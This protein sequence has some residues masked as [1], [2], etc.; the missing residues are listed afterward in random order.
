MRY[1]ALSFLERWIYD[2][3]LFI[4]INFKPK[5]TA[6]TK[7]ATANHFILSRTSWNQ[8]KVAKQRKEKAVIIFYKLTPF[9]GALTWYI[10]LT[11]SLSL[12]HFHSVTQLLPNSL[13]YTLSGILC[14]DTVS[15]SLLF[16]AHL[17]C[18]VTCSIHSP[19]QNSF[20]RVKCA[21]V[22]NKRFSFLNYTVSFISVTHFITW[23]NFE[24]EW[25]KKKKKKIINNQTNK[26]EK[27]KTLHKY[28]NSVIEEN[29]NEE[30]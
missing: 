20:T 4:W 10:S 7:S 25:S 5:I 28:T 15:L 1:R 2:L 30:K 14:C 29:P 18:L 11:C 24:G 21:Y 8:I 16:L 3:K 9:A 6:S 12:F 19:L 23:Q 27:R 17:L 13:T 22:Y 26:Q